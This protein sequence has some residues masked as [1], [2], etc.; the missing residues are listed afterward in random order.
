MLGRGREL[1]SRLSQGGA[2]SPPLYQA[3]WGACQVSG[4]GGGGSNPPAGWWWLQAPGALSPTLEVVPPVPSRQGKG[5]G[6][7]CLGQHTGGGGVQ[8]A[9]GAGTRSR[10]GT[11]V[12][13]N[14]LLGVC[15]GCMLVSRGVFCLCTS[16]LGGCR[17]SPGSP[18][19]QQLLRW[20]PPHTHTQV[21]GTRGSTGGACHLPSPGA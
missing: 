3:L 8:A 13:M 19:G 16:M 9:L 17:A 2:W 15:V 21:T 1:G 18:W 20:L 5:S 11:R 12:Q 10:T 4:G 7:R 6:L 14:V